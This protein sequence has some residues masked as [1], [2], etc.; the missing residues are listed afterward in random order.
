MAY[1]GDGDQQFNGRAKRFDIAVDFL[2]SAG[3]GA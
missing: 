1:A 2:I 3:N